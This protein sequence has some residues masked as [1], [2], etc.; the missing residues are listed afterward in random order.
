M[1]IAIIGAGPSGLSAAHYLI[2]IATPPTA[3][4]DV[5]AEI[6]KC[7]NTTG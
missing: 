6:V 5:I 4:F 2:L 3:I 7:F 1:K